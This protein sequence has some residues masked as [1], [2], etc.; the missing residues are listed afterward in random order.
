M[1]PSYGDV[2]NELSQI[3]IEVHHLSVR[4]SR[5]DISGSPTDAQDQWEATLICATATAKIY[6]GC[7]RVMARLATDVDGSAVAH[8][9][10]W[11]VGLLGRMA[12]PF[13]GVREAVISREC[14]TVL[15]KLRAFRHRERNTYG[16]NLDYGVV[17]KRA[18]EAIIGF[19]I[20]RDEVRIFLGGRES[21]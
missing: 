17:V 11:H 9:D 8:A 12:N 15:D 13:P 20:F 3:A 14:Y 5:L 6:T 7:E 4:L 1:H 2:E 10:G 19:D 16:I 18:S 21:P